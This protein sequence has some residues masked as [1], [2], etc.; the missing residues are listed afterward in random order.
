MTYKQLLHSQSLMITASSI[1]FPF[2]LLLLRNLGDSYSQFGLAYGIFALTAALS[3]PLIGAWSDRVGEKRLLILY[4]FGMAVVMLVI[5][6]LSTITQVYIIQVIMGLLGALQ[7]TAEKIAL[8]RQTDRAH[9]GKQ[10]GHYHLWT[11]IWAALAVI[12]TGYIIDF[13]TIGS[14]FYITSFMYVAGGVLI[15][16]KP[17]TVELERHHSL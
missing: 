4:T 8:S 14:L 2:Y 6:V 5:P 13:L 9:T 15:W 11:S 12:A 10:V 17:K 16:Q 3:H 7:K 1:V